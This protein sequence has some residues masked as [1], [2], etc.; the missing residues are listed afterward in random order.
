[1]FPLYT[2]YIPC[3]SILILV[4]GYV[5]WELYLLHLQGPSSNPE[6][7]CDHFEWSS[8][9]MRAKGKVLGK[10]RS[11]AF[12]QLQWYFPRILECNDMCFS[13]AKPFES[14]PWENFWRSL[15]DLQSLVLKLF[16][17]G[18]FYVPASCT[19]AFKA[20]LLFAHI[21]RWVSQTY[22]K[23]RSVTALKLFSKVTIYGLNVFTAELCVGHLNERMK[24]KVRQYSD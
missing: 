4:L 5:D 10:W 22:T 13:E 15:D 12:T 24:L 19:D 2:K 21:L 1:M 7:R 6:T 20:W 11:R 23:E 14:N 18:E 3:S 16:Q 17:A 9:S 8:S